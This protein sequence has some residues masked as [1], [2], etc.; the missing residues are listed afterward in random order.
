MPVVLKSVTVPRAFRVKRDRRRRIKK[1]ESWEAGR[2]KPRKKQADKDM[3]TSGDIRNI[4][5]ISANQ[6][7]FSRTDCVLAS[8]INFT[9]KHGKVK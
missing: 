9:I 4:K 1:Y 6:T 3:S 2:E 8:R 5:C 7:H